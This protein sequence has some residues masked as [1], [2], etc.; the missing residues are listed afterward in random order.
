MCTDDLG[1]FDKLFGV[2]LLE[3]MPARVAASSSRAS[4][5]IGT[6]DRLLA[7]EWP[8]CCSTRWLAPESLAFRTRGTHLR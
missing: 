8:P 3:S 7:L 1:L 2:F 5:R 6:A 4:Y